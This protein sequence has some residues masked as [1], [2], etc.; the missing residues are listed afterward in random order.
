[1]ATKGTKVAARNGQAAVRKTPAKR[2]RELPRLINEA[3]GRFESLAKRSLGYA[4]KVGALLNEAKR[5][6]DHGEWTGWLNEHVEFSVRTAQIYMQIDDQWNKTFGGPN[7]QN[8]AL[9]TE[10]MTEGMAISIADAVSRIRVTKVREKYDWA[11]AAGGEPGDGPKVPIPPLGE[12]ER[13]GSF[14]ASVGVVGQAE[15][16]EHQERL[17][18]EEAKLSKEQREAKEAAF[19]LDYEKARIRAVL[20]SVYVDWPP[21]RQKHFFRTVRAVVKEMEAEDRERRRSAPR[22]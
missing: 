18:A 16:A 9:S 8:S 1:V 22:A 15:A 13:S 4:R 10:G 20:G 7:A 2:L 14:P 6:V 11:D 21:S 5:G 12:E 3:H 19:D 17:R